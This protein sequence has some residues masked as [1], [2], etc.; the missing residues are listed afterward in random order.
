MKSHARCGIEYYAIDSEMSKLIV[1]VF[2][3][4]I[5]SGLGHSPTLAAREFSGEARFPSEALDGA[6]IKVR[7]NAASLTVTDEIRDGDRGEIERTLNEHVLE[8]N[9][10]PDIVFESSNVSASRAGNG[11]YWVNLVGE[12]SLHGVTR[13]QAVSAQVA[14]I[15]NTL[16]A[17]GGFSVQQSMHKIRLVSVAGGT[18]KLKDELKCS[19]DVLARKQ[20]QPVRNQNVH[21]LAPEVF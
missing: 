16:I 7:I 10:Y 11:Q 1:R 18:L 4:G 14:L 13:S 21:L 17:N 8:T 2:T 12:L 9:R 20:L 5:F 3:S 15:G 6:Y 19:F